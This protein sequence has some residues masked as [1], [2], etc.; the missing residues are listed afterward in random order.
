LPKTAL[1]HIFAAINLIRLNAF[2]E[3]KKR[4]RRGFRASPLWLLLI[5][6][7]NWWVCQRYLLTLFPGSYAVVRLRRMIFQMA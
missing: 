6:Q 4:R 3:G 5:S 1:P 2:L 7:D